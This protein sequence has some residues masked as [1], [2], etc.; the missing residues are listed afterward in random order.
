MQEDEILKIAQEAVQYGCSSKLFLKKII[1]RCFSQHDLLPN[2]A[3]QIIKSNKNEILHRNYNSVDGL[4]EFVRLLDSADDCVGTALLDNG[5][6]IPGLDHYLVT[7]SDAVFLRYFQSVENFSDTIF[8]RLGRIKDLESAFDA[9]KIKKIIK[10]YNVKINSSKK[11]IDKMNNMLYYHVMFLA[12]CSFNEDIKE[13]YKKAFIMIS[14][15]Q[16]DPTTHFYVRIKITPKLLK[17]LQKVKD[18]KFKRQLG[19]EFLRVADAQTRVRIAEQYVFF[20]RL[21]NVS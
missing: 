10:Y 4:M 15:Y 13:I 8:E 17:S 9:D 1:K 2:I 21:L 16:A 12:R 11:E 19:K 6:F 5:L 20:K 18:R 3:N 14:E 7:C